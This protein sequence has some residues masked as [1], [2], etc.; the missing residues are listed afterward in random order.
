[1]PAIV[2]DNGEFIALG[3]DIKNQTREEI[4]NIISQLRIVEGTPYK[5]IEH[6]SSFS[7]KSLYYCKNCHDVKYRAQPYH[8]QNH[9][10]NI[11]PEY[12]HIAFELERDM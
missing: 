5:S 8:E 9:E 12:P 11:N 4:K 1:M 10:Q 6:K 7:M 3:K 2:F